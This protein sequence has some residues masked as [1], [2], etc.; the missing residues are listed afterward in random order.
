M[1]TIGVI[2]G[3][4]PQ[5]T[6]AFEEAVHK[7]SGELI[8]HFEN[9]GYPPMV[10]YYLRN[11]PMVLAEGKPKLPLEADPRLLEAVRKVSQIADFIVIVSN[12]PHIF[13]SQ[14]KDVAA[15][16]VV[17]MIDVVVN[18]VKARG[19]K[20]VGLLAVGHTLRSGLYQTPLGEIG[21]QIEQVQDEDLLSKI[22]R[23]IFAVMEGEKP[24]ADVVLEGIEKLKAIGVEAIILG[25]T[26]LPLI[27]G[28][29]NEGQELID[30][31][32][33]LAEAAVRFALTKD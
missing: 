20:K 21:V 8:V 18:E 12:T 30:P 24:S 11:A 4:G 14:I 5:A 31:A 6:I 23:A 19:L 29:E 25:C 26:E 27:L 1:K 17:G 7:V 2:G 13:L 10:V 32:K 28:A 15:K 33:L 9:Q 22:D 16:P 3:L